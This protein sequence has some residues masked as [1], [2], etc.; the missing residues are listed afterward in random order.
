MYSEACVSA[1]SHVSFTH[2]PLLGILGCIY[3]VFD[4]IVLSLL[5]LA[6]LLLAGFMLFFTSQSTPIA[7]PAQTHL[8][9]KRK[10][11]LPEAETQPLF[12]NQKELENFL[13]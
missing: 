9:H 10:K 6:L 1:L 7:L 5:V 8:H 12:L 4:V 2:T 11:L 13:L 3:L